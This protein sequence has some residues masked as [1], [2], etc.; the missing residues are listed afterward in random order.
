[1]SERRR[2]TLLVIDE[3][4]EYFERIRD[5]AELCRHQCV[6]DCHFS[7]SAV[8]AEALIS[9]LHPEVVLVDAHLPDTN[10]LALVQACSH[11]NVPVVVASESVS[12]D[13]GDSARKFGAHGYVSKSDDPEEIEALLTQ[14]VEMAPV[15]PL[16]H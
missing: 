6:V 5:C 9:R 10:S 15:L 14:L 16:E 11:E 8:G 1:M 3:H 13:I 7:S 2:L 12:S 4:R